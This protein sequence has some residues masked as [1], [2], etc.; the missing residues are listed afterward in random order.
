MGQNQRFPMFVQVWSNFLKIKDICE[1]IKYEVKF[2]L[3][4]F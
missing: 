2:Y 4:I 3:N 1:T